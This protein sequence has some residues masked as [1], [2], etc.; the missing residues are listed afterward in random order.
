VPQVAAAIPSA[1]AVPPAPADTQASQVPFSRAADT[2]GSTP[3]AATGNT[4]EKAIQQIASSFKNTYAVSDK[5][6]TIFKD[7]TGK[8][9]TRYV[10]LRDGSVT[11]VPTTPTVVRPAQVITTAGDGYV[12]I[13]A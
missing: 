10:S 8:Y 6:F 7:A 13:D 11:Y 12:A 2:T 1:A 5:Q 3:A 4:F 9:I